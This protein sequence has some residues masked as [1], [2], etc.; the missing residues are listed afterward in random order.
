MRNLK[1][2]IDSPKNWEYSGRVVLK[3]GKEVTPMLD[4]TNCIQTINARRELY[5]MPI[6]TLAERTGIP[7]DALY[8]IFAGRRKLGASELLSIASVLGL[9]FDDFRVKGDTEHDV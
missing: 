5:G 1:K 8:A 2:A 7:S 4:T 6:A 3:I 9:D